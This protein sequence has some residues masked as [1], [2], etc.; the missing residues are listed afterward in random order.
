MSANKPVT[1]CIMQSPNGNLNQKHAI[2][3]LQS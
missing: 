2:Y 3:E 1:K